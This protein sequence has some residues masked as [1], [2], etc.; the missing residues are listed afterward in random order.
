MKNLNLMEYSS[1]IKYEVTK[2]KEKEQGSQSIISLSRNDCF[3]NCIAF[4]ES[5][6]SRKHSY[7]QKE[8]K[9]YIP[10]VLNC[11]SVRLNTKPVTVSA[12]MMLKNNL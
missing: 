2:Y 11:K 3:K 7:T 12:I 6:S 9:L 5:S 8:A 1:C 4:L 10:K